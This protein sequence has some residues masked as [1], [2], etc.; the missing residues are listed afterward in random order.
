VRAPTQYGPGLLARAAYFNLYQLLPAAR[1]SEALRDLFGCALSPAT[2]ERASRRISG[3][4]VRT[5][6]RIK[7]A[8]G[9]SPVVGADE[10]GLR[11]AGRGGWVHVA[12]TDALTHLAYDSRRGCE[13]TRDVGILPRLRGTLV[14]D[15]YLSYTRFEGCR[16]SLCNAHLLRELL[17]V[18]ESDPAQVVWTKPLASLLLEIKEAA[19]GAPAAGQAQLSEAAEDTYL[20][21]YDRLVKKADRLN[22]QPPPAEDE[23]DVPKT[24]ETCRR[25]GSRRSPRHVGSS[26]GCCA[27]ARK[28]S[29]S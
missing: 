16:H 20:R 10:T 26:T 2:V 17:F 19:A 28:S 14:R 15:G 25:S 4:L 24:K 23:G 29:A 13:A 3:K 12:R 27:G 21:R 6:Q 11:V 9:D 8:I 5:Q 22:R 1:T 18:G 7:T